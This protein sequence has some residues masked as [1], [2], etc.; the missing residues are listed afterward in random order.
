MAGLAKADV[1]SDVSEA[2]VCNIYLKKNK[3][4]K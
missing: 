2:Q 4:S 3:L 1:L